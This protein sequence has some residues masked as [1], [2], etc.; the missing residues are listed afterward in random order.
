MMHGSLDFL[1]AKGF[2]AG[3]GEGLGDIAQNF[4]ANRRENPQP[5]NDFR[6]GK[7]FLPETFPEGVFRAR[8]KVFHERAFAI[9]A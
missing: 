2:I 1:Q 3:L 8:R 9:S 4:I 6:T 7:H 5:A